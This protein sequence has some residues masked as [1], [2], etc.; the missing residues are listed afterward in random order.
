LNVN[1]ILNGQKVGPLPLLAE[2]LDRSGYTRGTLAPEA[3]MSAPVPA[4]RP[5]PVRRL[6]DIGMGALA[7]GDMAGMNHDKMGQAN[8]LS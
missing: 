4:L 6:R 3:G 5:R 2:S 7:G 1:G 8:T